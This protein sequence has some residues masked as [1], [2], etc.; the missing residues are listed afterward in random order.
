MFGFSIL[1]RHLVLCLLRLAS[2][3]QHFAIIRD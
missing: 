2:I 3:F 1:I